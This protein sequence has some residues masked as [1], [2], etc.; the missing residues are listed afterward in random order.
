M[1]YQK[2]KLNQLDYLSLHGKPFEL[3]PETEQ[4]GTKNLHNLLYRL[5]TTPIVDNIEVV[6]GWITEI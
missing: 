6:F 2:G 3:I 5:Q 1:I 4:K